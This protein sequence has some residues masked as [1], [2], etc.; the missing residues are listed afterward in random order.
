MDNKNVAFVGGVDVDICCGDI[1]GSMIFPVKGNSRHKL[2]SGFRCTEEVVT[3]STVRNCFGSFF[4]SV[5]IELGYFHIYSLNWRRWDSGIEL[6]KQGIQDLKIMQLSL[7][8]L[9][10]QYTLADHWKRTPRNFFASPSL[11]RLKELQR[12]DSRVTDRSSR[13][14]RGTGEGRVRERLRGD[15]DDAV[16]DMRIEM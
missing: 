13:L 8:N 12:Q 3:F 4:K 1:R 6:N 11:W 2:F 14:T 15:V 16:I 10:E 9:L 7:E 5:R